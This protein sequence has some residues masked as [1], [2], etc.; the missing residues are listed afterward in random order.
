MSKE[1]HLKALPYQDILDVQSE[2]I[3]LRSWQKSL[4]YLDESFDE[5]T[6]KNKKD[7]RMRYYSCAQLHQIFSNDFEDVLTKSE[8]IVRQMMQ[9]GKISV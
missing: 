4:V 2:L 7:I 3:K 5:K 9:R 1:Q 6:T 8:T